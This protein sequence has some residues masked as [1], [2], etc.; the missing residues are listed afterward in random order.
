MASFFLDFLL[1]KYTYI[2]TQQALNTLCLGYLEASV[3]AVD[4]EFVRERTFSAK[5]G[6]LQ[7]YDGKTLALIDPLAIDDLSPFWAILTDPN[8]VKVLH[9][10]S[11]DFEVFRNY[12]QLTVTSIFDSQVA[13][14]LTGQGSSLGYGKLIENQLDILLDKGESRTNWL[15]RPLS[16]A[17]LQYA[18]NDVYYLY[19]VYFKLIEQLQANGKTSICE[20]ESRRLSIKVPTNNAQ[21]KYVD[22]SGAWQLVPEQLAVLQQLTQ[23]RYQEAFKR[24]LA[25][26]F[27]LKDAELL[28]I[29]KETPQDLSQLK[30]LQQIHPMV[31]KRYGNRILQLVERGMNQEIL[32]PKLTRLVDYPCYKQQFKAIKSLVEK[33]ATESDIPKEMIASKKLIHEVLSF[34]WKKE[35]NNQAQPVLFSGWRHEV[36]GQEIQQLLINTDG[37]T[38]KL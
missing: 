15:A 9:A 18:A 2:D 31:V 19:Q 21:E 36:V 14:A 5:L 10:G 13:A 4:T 24:D 11:E 7:A 35:L 22:I 27:V 6:L 1:V 12:G 32:P 17:Q 33:V 34:Y 25:L 23:W 26:G 20:Q 3:V 30:A 28:A 8:I 37:A 29:A 16:S 38:A